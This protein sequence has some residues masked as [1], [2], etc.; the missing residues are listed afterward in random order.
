[1]LQLA[2]ISVG[3]RLLDNNKWTWKIED[4]D[5]KIE[6]TGRKEFNTMEDALDELEVFCKELHKTQKRTI[7]SLRKS[8]KKGGSAVGF[9]T[10]RR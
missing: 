2:G 1:M 9:A 6:L 7:K 10:M 8:W 3:V 4:H 5:R